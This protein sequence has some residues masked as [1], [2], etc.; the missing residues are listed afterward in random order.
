[1]KSA[2]RIMLVAGLSLCGGLAQAQETTLPW[3]HATSLTGEAKYPQ[4]FKHYDYVNPQ[5]PKG[6][7]LNQV[8]VGTF[9]T[10]NPYVV[11][12]VPA[13]GLSGLGGGMLYDTLMDQSVDQ[14]STSYGMRMQYKAG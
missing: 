11:Q 9:D 12:G 13:A 4:G 8:T 10:L 1:M 5:A 6:G 7:T 2:L 14:S 3:H